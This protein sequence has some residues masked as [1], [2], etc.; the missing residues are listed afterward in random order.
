MTAILLVNPLHEINF[1]Q[2]LQGPVNRDQS[3]MFATRAGFE[4]D[5]RWGECSVTLHDDIHDDLPG[6]GKPVTTVVDSLGPGISSVCH[7]LMIMIIFFIILQ[8]PNLKQRNL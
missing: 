6:T 4:K 7:F 1:L 3:H 2:F 5:I 8:F